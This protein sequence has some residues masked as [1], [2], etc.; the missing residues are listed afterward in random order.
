MHCISFLS[1]TPFIPFIYMCVCVYKRQF[2]H[3]VFLT[4]QANHFSGFSNH[5]SS[6]IPVR[7]S[8]TLTLSHSIS[9]SRRN[10]KG[11]RWAVLEPCGCA[12]YNIPGK[13]AISSS[14]TANMTITDPPSS[15]FSVCLR[16]SL[17][18]WGTC[19]HITDFFKCVCY[20]PTFRNLISLHCSHV[21]PTLKVK[22]ISVI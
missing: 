3:A 22:M 14:A 20:C 9:G 15:S 16:A 21:T 2:M 13:A 7:R 11:Q 5:R 18:A 17:W 6:R 10:E 12:S 8:I 19:W 4:I 1:E